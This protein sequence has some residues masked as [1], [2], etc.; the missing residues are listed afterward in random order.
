MTNLQIN[1]FVQLNQETKYG[2]EFFQHSVK[3]QEGNQVYLKGF[4]SPFTLDGDYLKRKNQI[5][6]IEGQDGSYNTHGK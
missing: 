5:W 4:R 6:K 2:T 1:I 3:M